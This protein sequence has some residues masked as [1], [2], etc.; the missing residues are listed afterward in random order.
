M[1]GGNHKERKA[2]WEKK[3]LEFLILL[4]LFFNLPV[5]RVTELVGYKPDDLIGRSAFEFHHALDSNQMNKW[6]HICE[7]VCVC[8]CVLYQ[9]KDTVHNSDH[10][11][12][13]FYSF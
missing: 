13:L 11:V 6:L 2:R 12:V 1:R 4:L 8:V 7:F 9:K 5:S 3:S 10:K